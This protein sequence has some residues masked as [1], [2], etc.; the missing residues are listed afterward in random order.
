M[1]KCSRGLRTLCCVGY[2]PENGS[3]SER[4]V[5]RANNRSYNPIKNSALTKTN[6]NFQFRH[7]PKLSIGFNLKGY[8][9]YINDIWMKLRDCWKS[10]NIDFEYRLVWSAPGGWALSPKLV[11]MRVYKER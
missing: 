7:V 8:K 4:T 10:R 6:I 11:T 3:I 9:H 5:N 1:A 2:F